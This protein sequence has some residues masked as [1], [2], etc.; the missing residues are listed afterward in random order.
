MLGM[1]AMLDTYFCLMHL[2]VGIYLDGAFKA[3]ATAAFLKFVLFAMF[4]MRYLL[5]VWKSRRPQAFSQGWA[6]MRRELQNLYTRFCTLR[7]CNHGSN[8][9][10]F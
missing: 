2:T 7:L 9:F 10:R 1:Q 8:C 5:F 6:A 4:E 3:F